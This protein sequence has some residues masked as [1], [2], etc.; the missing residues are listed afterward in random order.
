VPAALFL[1][2]LALAASL[3][4]PAPPAGD[5]EARIET[6]M[7]AEHVEQAAR[8][9]RVEQERV[10]AAEL[11]RVHA[12]EQFP[13]AAGAPIAYEALESMKGRGVRV[14]TTSGHTRIGIVQDVD[15]RQVRLRAQLHGGY[16]EYMVER[17]QISTIE[18]E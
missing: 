11:D 9:E 7:G 6:L 18:A 16:A 13:P 2:V 4:Q 8:A 14:H 17:R 10:E 12:E 3:G 5:D 1:S 15:K